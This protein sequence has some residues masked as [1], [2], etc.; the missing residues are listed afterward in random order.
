MDV[1]Y[2][3]LVFVYGVII[4]SFLNVCIYRIPQRTSLLSGRSYC[5]HCDSMIRAYD[6]VPILSYL[7]LRG[8][9]RAAL[10]NEFSSHKCSR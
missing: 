2:T 8:R 10:K 6:N 3:V 7:L 4:G 1:V 9:C 5:P